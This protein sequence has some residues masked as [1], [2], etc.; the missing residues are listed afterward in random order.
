MVYELKTKVNDADISDF[1]NTIEDE[2]KK[3]D[4]FQLLDIFAKLSGKEPKMW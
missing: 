2:T 4:S 1:L 3:E